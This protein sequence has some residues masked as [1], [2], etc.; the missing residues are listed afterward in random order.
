MPQSPDIYDKNED[1]KIRIPLRSL[2]LNSNRFKEFPPVMDSNYDFEHEAKTADF[3]KENVNPIENYK[4]ELKKCHSYD[5]QSLGSPQTSNVKL[6]AHSNSAFEPFQQVKTTD[7]GSEVLQDSMFLISKI[8]DIL[9]VNHS[10]QSKLSNKLDYTLCWSLVSSA[11][12]QSTSDETQRLYNKYN[13]LRQQNS[14]P[15]PQLSEDYKECRKLY[16]PTTAN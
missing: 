5:R 11:L 14:V 6:A 12:S 16:F 7:T 3:D 2:N 15:L 10:N 13:I 4:L 8:E 9:S 1:S